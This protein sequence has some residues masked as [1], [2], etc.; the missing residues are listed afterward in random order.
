M[1]AKTHDCAIDSQRTD[2]E[3]EE[4]AKMKAARWGL[5]PVVAL[6][7]SPAGMAAQRAI[8]VKG[9]ATFA[10]PA[11]EGG[12]GSETQGGVIGGV[13][14]SLPAT[15][16][17]SVQIEA[18]YRQTGFSNLDFLVDGS[19]VDIPYLDIPVLLKFRMSETPGRVRPS[20][21]GGL[22]YGLELSCSTTGGIVD[23]EGNDT[24][25]GRFRG[26]GKADVGVIVGASVDI[27]VVNRVYLL[28]DGRYQYGLRNLHYEPDSESTH[29]RSWSVMGGIGI[30]LGT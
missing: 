29:S 13:F 10:N 12:F 8:G 3:T 9:G 4:Y 7:L 25:D 1:S 27:E 18:M 15:N 16:R 20:L 11:F 30:R 19:G 26:R 21:L 22:F 28:V 14:I 23:L 5:V 6:L 24:C 2:E 17:L